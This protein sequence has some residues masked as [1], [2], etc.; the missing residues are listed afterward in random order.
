MLSLRFFGD[1]FEEQG[2]FS[3]HLSRHGFFISL[4]LGL[5][6]FRSAC[7]QMVLPVDCCII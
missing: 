2:D 5:Q 6:D 4:L 1:L 3:P 7:L